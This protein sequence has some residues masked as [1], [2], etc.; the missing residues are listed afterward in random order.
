MKDS[1]APFHPPARGA[2]ALQGRGDGHAAVAAQCAA[3]PLTV[4]TR[5][6]H[7]A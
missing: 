2:A 6:K 5:S 4:S 7:T 3:L 1:M